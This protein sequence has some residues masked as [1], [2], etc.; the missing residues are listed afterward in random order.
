MPELK[1]VL[2]D[3][4][5]DEQWGSW[6]LDPLAQLIAAEEDE[7]PEGQEVNRFLIEYRST[8]HTINE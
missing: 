1:E 8:K 2:I 4:P 5:L 3:I 6:T 7:P